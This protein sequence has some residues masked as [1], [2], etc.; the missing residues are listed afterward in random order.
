MRKVNLNKVD[1]S[2]FRIATPLDVREV[3]IR[4]RDLVADL[5]GFRVAIC[6]N[7]AV[8]K[9]MHD[10]QGNILATSVFGW[11]GD[12]NDRWWRTPH[13]ALDSP[14]PTACRYESEPFWCN[15]DGF[16][17]SI[18]NPLLDAIDLTDFERRSLTTAAIAVPVHLPFGQ[19][20]AASFESPD[21]SKHDLSAEFET[22]GD[23]L[24]LL[25][26][27]FVA[28]YVRAMCNAER[29]P[30]DAGLSKREVECLRWAAVGKTD[31]EIGLIMSR[32]RA[33][34]RFHLHEASVK[35]DAV[36][37]AQTLFKAAQLGYIGLNR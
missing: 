29:L 12:E 28:G 35:L 23:L 30:V 34:V 33:T 5:M 24:G 6:H 19:I 8:K 27:T 31:R 3:A 22:Y 13:L 20:G 11:T 9:P 16:R 14:L 15:A 2:D 32:T 17:T 1:L 26:R 21:R 36:N 37:R 7:I 25:T 4:L 10:A 18:P